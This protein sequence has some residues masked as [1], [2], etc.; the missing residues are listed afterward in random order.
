MDSKEVTGS[1]TK[2]RKKEG[3]P[4]WRCMDDVELDLRNMGAK[5]WRT[6]VLDRTERASVV[7]A[8]TAKL[9]GCSA[10]EEDTTSTVT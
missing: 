3:R 6:R 5:R 8:A 10:K 7:R 1:Q 4:R 2:R 9:K